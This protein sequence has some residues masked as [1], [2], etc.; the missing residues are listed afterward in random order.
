MNKYFHYLRSFGA[1]CE[2][3]QRSGKYIFTNISRTFKV[4]RGKV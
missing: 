1:E 2:T 3:L 4:P